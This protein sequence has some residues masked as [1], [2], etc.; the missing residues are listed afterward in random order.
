MTMN[1]AS[2]RPREARF[3]VRPATPAD[4]PA[5]WDLVR[6][7]AA[8][9][10]HEHLATGS[11][12]MLNANLFGDAWPR[13]ECLVAETEGALGGYA[14]FYGT[15]STFWTRPLLWLEDLF[16]RERYRGSGMGLA[17]FREVAR[18]AVARACPRMDWAVLDWNQPAMR[19]YESLG[20]TRHG[21]WLGYRLSDEKLRDFA[22][23][24]TT[25]R[26]DAN[27]R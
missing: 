25:P 17:L 11:A 7:F 21:G 8:F 2:D 4:V 9:E 16:V 3:T 14:L 10:K 23:R 15:Y 26:T 22:A 19:F 12:E 27:S 1:A 18:I 13:I 5:V 24:G 6:D 20:A